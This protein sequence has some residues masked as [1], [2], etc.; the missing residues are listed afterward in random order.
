MIM[1]NGKAAFVIEKNKNTKLGNIRKHWE[2]VG[3]QFPIEG[4]VTPTSRDP[5]LALLER[6]NIIYHLKEFYVALEIGCGDGSHT[7]NYAKNVKRL[8]GIDIAESLIGLA[9]SR[10]NSESIRNVDFL[11]GSVLDIDR[12]YPLQRFNCIISQ[13]CFINLPDWPYQQDAILQSYRLLNKEGLLLLTEGFQEE[14]ENLNTLRHKFGLPQIEVVKYNK[15]LIRKDFEAFVN[16]Y[17]DIIEVR[18]YGLYL[19]LSRIYHPLAVFP[20][21]PKHDSR[22]NEVAMVVSR[23]IQIPDLKR[24][25]YNLFY[26]LRKK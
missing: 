12:I 13:R 24:Y 1:I 17:F 8:S 4:R 10:A 21:E 19:F 7:I 3:K 23:I 18:D 22:L 25:S 16:R 20:D 26:V 14:L 9:K 2:E 11:V 15:N 5:Y 6:E